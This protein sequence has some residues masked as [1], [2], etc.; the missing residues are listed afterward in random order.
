MLNELEQ[1]RRS[2]KENGIETKAWHPSI[3]PLAKYSTLL[4]RL[5]DE[6]VPTSVSL[7]S[8]EQ[9]GRLRN[10]QPDNQKSFPAFNLNSPMFRV[11]AGVDASCKDTLMS[12]E[13]VPSLELAYEQ[14]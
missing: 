3:K 9:A 2:L 14:R 5:N 6:G 12:P 8:R 4:V 10:F 1:L 7:L 11:P 13:V